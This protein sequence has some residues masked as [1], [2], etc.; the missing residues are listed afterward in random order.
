M[1]IMEA[2][3]RSRSDEMR[4]TV[5]VPSA[6][7]TPD[8]QARASVFFDKIPRFSEMII[9]NRAISEER[10]TLK[11]GGRVDHA[12]AF[13]RT[14]PMSVRSLTIRAGPTAANG[15]TLHRHQNTLLAAGRDI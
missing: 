8:F 10:S 7:R 9:V 3:M 4:D 11:T 14:P 13:P 12:R 1:G 5:G 2:T 6:L 15:A